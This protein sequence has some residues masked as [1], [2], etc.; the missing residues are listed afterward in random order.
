MTTKKLKNKTSK[1]KNN[2]TKLGSYLLRGKEPEG[3]IDLLISLTSMT[4]ETMLKNLKRYY[5][6]GYDVPTLVELFNV[7][8]SNFNRDASKLEE[9]A[10]IMEALYVYKV[11]E[12][13]SEK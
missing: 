11:N 10:G 8:Q 1:A 9:V 3:K 4:S 12:E 2:R 5:C 7:S 13:K 6:Q